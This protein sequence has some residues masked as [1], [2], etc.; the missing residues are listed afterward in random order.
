MGAGASTAASAAADAN[1]IP[2]PAL[3]LRAAVADEMTTEH[4]FPLTV[5]GESDVQC[6]ELRGGADGHLKSTQ[7]VPLPAEYTRRMS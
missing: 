5:P 2:P 3:E 4:D 6:W 1:A 7:P